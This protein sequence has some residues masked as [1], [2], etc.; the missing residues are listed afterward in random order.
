MAT[1]LAQIAIGHYTVLSRRGPAGVLLRDVVPTAEAAVVGAKLQNEAEHLRFMT[2]RVGLYPFGQYGVLA[3]PLVFGFALETQT[4]SLFPDFVFTGNAPESGY[5]PVQVHELAH[6]WFGDDV[7]PEKWADVWLNEGHATWYEARY[8]DER[9]WEPFEGRMRAA[10]AA[11]D[12][13]RADYGPVASPPADNLFN[14]TVYD[15][16]AAR[17]ARA[18]RRRTHS[19]SRSPSRRRAGAS[20]RREGC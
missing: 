11:G 4:L 18:R 3:A 15:G 10:Y 7:S 9:G 16:G 17:R 13:W 20:R 12:Q 1:E 6:K 14:P 8:A 5:A 19:C 2:S